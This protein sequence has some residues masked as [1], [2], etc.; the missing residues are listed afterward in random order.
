VLKKQRVHTGKKD[1]IGKR[2][3]GIPMWA[4][5]FGV[6]HIAR[7]KRDR[8][9]PVAAPLVQLRSAGHLAGAAASILMREYVAAPPFQSDQQGLNA[10]RAAHAC[11]LATTYCR[12]QIV[13]LITF[14]SISLV[15]SRSA[16]LVKRLV[17]DK[18]LLD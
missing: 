4:F 15:Q 12:I 10:K 7:A 11:T 5:F 9:Y 6:P 17:T 1:K 2:V 18:V 16:L 3:A 13:A 8:N 14:H